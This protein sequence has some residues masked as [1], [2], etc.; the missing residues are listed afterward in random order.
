MCVQYMYACIRLYDCMIALYVFYMC[1][2]YIYAFVYIWVHVYIYIPIAT[3]LYILCH[4]VPGA[5]V[6]VVLFMYI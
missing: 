2:P 3:V 5:Y 6:N 4:R 1:A